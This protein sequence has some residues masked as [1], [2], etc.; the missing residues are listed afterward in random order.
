MLR[1]YSYFSLDTDLAGEM[2]EWPE[3]VNGEGYSVDLKDVSANEEVFV[4]F[5]ESPDSFPYVQIWS[6]NPGPLFERVV[7]RAVVALSAHSDN[8]MVDRYQFP[9][10]QT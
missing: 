2:R 9:E 4:R 5:F 6:N 3:F 1:I 10:S 8:L 7:G